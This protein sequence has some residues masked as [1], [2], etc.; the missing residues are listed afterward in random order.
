[1]SNH[2]VDVQDTPK[3]L[4]VFIPNIIEY[5]S[6]ISPQLSSEHHLTEIMG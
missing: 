4:S 3:F 1:M 2:A 5:P 6:W